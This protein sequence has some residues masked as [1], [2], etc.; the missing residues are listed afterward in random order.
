MPS[1]KYL[2]VIHA[3]ATDHLVIA[4]YQ[5]TTRATAATAFMNMYRKL[6]PFSSLP[7]HRDR[8]RYLGRVYIDDLD[9]KIG[10]RHSRSEHQVAI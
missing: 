1:V 5:I 7:N 9:N 2:C 3:R 8:A 6:P 4:V 10:P